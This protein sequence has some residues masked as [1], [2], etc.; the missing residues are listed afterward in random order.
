MEG[1]YFDSYSRKIRTHRVRKHGS[2]RLTVEAA[3]ST[4]SAWAE[5]EGSEWTRY[6][7]PDWLSNSRQNTEKYFLVERVPFPGS[8]VTQSSFQAAQLVFISSR[9][10][11]WSLLLFSWL[12]SSSSPLVQLAEP[13]RSAYIILPVM[14][15]AP[16]RDHSPTALSLLVS[17]QQSMMSTGVALWRS[18][19]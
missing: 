19:G 8:S 9:Q 4:G 15:E 5:E 12:F 3:G 10:P 13:V 17:R 1:I 2:K 14:E 16:W 11:S 18:E 7:R 6:L